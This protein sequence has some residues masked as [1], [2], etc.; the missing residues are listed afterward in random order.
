MKTIFRK[1]MTRGFCPIV[2]MTILFILL[3]PG[4][5]YGQD[6][7]GINDGINNIF[8]WIFDFGKAHN[9]L[10]GGTD[11]DIADRNDAIG[12][13][14]EFATGGVDWYFSGHETIISWVN[15]E[16]PIPLDAGI[17]ALASI[18]IMIIVIGF[19][20]REHGKHALI[21]LGAFGIL[22]VGL[23]LFNINFQI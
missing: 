15:S 7:L 20:L 22:I 16:S 23:I 10:S 19:M 2:V 18:L 4:Q 1:S 11:D 9:N 3:T 17:I 13:T 12:N 21:I 5:V 8:E 14:E 6:A